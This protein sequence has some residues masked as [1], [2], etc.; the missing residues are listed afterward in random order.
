MPFAEVAVNSTAPHRRAFTYS[1]PA[2]LAVAEGQAV[3]VPFGNRTLQGV[4]LEVTDQP[5]YPETRD[6]IAPMDSRPLLLPQHTVLARWLSDYYLAPLFDCV[7][8]MLP[9][10][11][12]RKPL[13]LLRPLVSAEEVSSLEL[14]PRQREVLEQVAGRRRVELEELRKELKLRGLSAA[15]EELVRRELVERT[16]ELARPKVKPKL[17]PHVRLLVKPSGARKRAKE[18]DAS[19]RERRQAA[20]LTALVEEGPLMPLAQLRARTG[21]TNAGLKGLV[22]GGLVALEEVEVERDPLAARSYPPRE[23]PVLTAAQQT[24]YEEIAQALERP[25]AGDGGSPSA[26]LLHG[27]TG[28]GK[29]EV[30]LQALEKAVALGKR[31]IVLVP[32]IS[33]TPQTVRRFAER[34]PGRVAVMHSGLSPGEQFDQWRGIRDG[35]Y[36]VVIGP[37][38]A[39]FAPQPDLALIVMDE[40]HEWTYKQQ[41][42]APRYHARRA[43]EKLAELTGAVLVLGS[44]TPDLESYYRASSGGYRLL[45]LR[46]RVQPQVSGNGRSCVAR[47]LPEVQVVDLRQEL[48]AGNRSIFSRSLAQ[49]LAEALAADEQVILFLNRRG[50]ASFVQCRDCGYVPT[51]SRCA[52]SLTYHASEERL[53]CHHCHRGR[54]L[55]DRCPQ[56]DSPRIRFM[57]IGT[58]KVEQEAGRAFPQ[59]RLLRWDRDVTRHRGAHERILAR[60]LAKEA[61]ILIGT[62]MIAKGLDMPSVTLVGVIS[63]DVSLN[64]PD[65]RSGERTFQL[66]EQVAGRAGRGPLGGRVV[67]QTYTPHHWAIQAAAR[68]DYAAFYEHEALLRRRLGYPPFGRLARLIFAHTNPLYAQEQALRLAR[69]LRR[70]KDIRGIPHLDILGPAPS[71][72]PKMRGRHRWQILL[73][74]DDPAELLRG[75]SFP[76][77]WTIDIDPISLL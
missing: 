74:G 68:H 8:L 34:F 71:F 22:D 14:T 24:A 46:E 67:I 61:D 48:K 73:R 58:E 77:G 7:A 43:A 50:A 4:V 57:G 75:L 6:I 28:S 32:E 21:I 55:P 10:G 60:F 2:G 13:T 70:E 37:R 69:T 64:L 3:Y 9:P 62:Q 65:Y 51:C 26:F 19:A 52:V 38:S 17:V 30:Y 56:C 72:V 63:A 33:L 16:Y 18:L 20:A 11:F 25:A 40:E 47:P 45:E 12:R 35:R 42:P 76:Q 5:S 23:P 1:L 36:A 31:G 54:R 27:V 29:T 59:A 49:A 39:I 41:D 44:A 53:I 66:L 15:V